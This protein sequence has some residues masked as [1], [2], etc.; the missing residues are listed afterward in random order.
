VSSHDVERN[1]LEQRSWN[2]F[3]NV[4]TWWTFS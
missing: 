4:F 3:F 2:I 1:N